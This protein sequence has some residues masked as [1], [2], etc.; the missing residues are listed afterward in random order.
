MGAESD[1]L[2]GRARAPPDRLA[3][4]GEALQQANGLKETETIPFREELVR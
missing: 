3:L 1:D 2:T 4:R